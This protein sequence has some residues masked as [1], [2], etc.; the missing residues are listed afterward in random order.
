MISWLRAIA[1]NAFDELRRL[2]RNRSVLLVLIGIPIVYPVLVS[3]L[4]ERNA[5]VERPTVMVD[6]DG[7]ALSRNLAL[8]LDATQ[9]ISI[10]QRLGDLDEGFE[11]VRSR[12]VEMLIYVPPDFSTRVRSG[13]RGTFKVW[14]NSANML[15]YGAAVGAT[16]LTVAALN[17]DLGRRLFHE[18]GLTTELADRR[19]MPIGIDSR[20]L[21]YRQERM[22]NSSSPASF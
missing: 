11:M 12:Q 17:E 18:Q 4:Y 22:G 7:S 10:E 13:R 2:G 14:I 16:R 21:F 8:S 1:S 15:T 20:R 9:E 6:H 5:P 3:W 19:I